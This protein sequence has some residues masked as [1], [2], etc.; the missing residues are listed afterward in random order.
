MRNLIRNVLTRVRCATPACQAFR[1]DVGALV[2][3][4][5]RIALWGRNP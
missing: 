5:L 2:V 1:G 4:V 3:S